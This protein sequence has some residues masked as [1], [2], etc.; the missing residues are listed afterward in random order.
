MAHHIQIRVVNRLGAPLTNERVSL[1]ASPL[2]STSAIPDQ[3]TDA[4]GLANFD[5]DVQDQ[6]ELA[7]YVRG[8]ERCRMAPLRDRYDIAI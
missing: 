7:V 6:A 4:Q 2:T 5:I 3:T 8:R 1:F